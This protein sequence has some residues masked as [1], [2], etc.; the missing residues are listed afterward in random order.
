LYTA[1]SQSVAVAVNLQTGATV[2]TLTSPHHASQADLL[3][4]TTGSQHTNN[5][6]SISNLLWMGRVD[7]TISI[8]EPLTG[9]MD[10]QFTTAELMSVNDMLLT[11]RGV[12][13]KGRTSTAPG[14]GM[15]SSNGDDDD[16]QRLLAS[17]SDVLVS[18]TSTATTRRHNMIATPSGSLAFLDEAG[19]IAWVAHETFDTPVAFALDS[20]TGFSLTIEYV[21]DA[22]APNGSSDHI[23]KEMKRQLELGL[24]DA[25]STALTRAHQDST[26]FGSLPQSGQL[27]A[28]PLGQRQP[29]E[30]S[31]ASESSASHHPT[32]N[33]ASSSAL[34]A[35]EQNTAGSGR[36][37]HQ[38]SDDNQHY[39]WQHHGDSRPRP[40]SCSP[41]NPFYP[42]CL[43]GSHDR[44]RSHPHFIPEAAR[45]S[46]FEVGADG[47]IVPFYHPEYGYR[48][49][50]PDQFYM[51]QHEVYNSRKRYQKA[52]MVFGSWLPAL[53]VVIF[54][55]VR[56][57]VLV[58]VS[59]IMRFVLN[60][61]W[62]RSCIVHSR[63]SL[64]G[65]RSKKTKSMR[66]W[67]TPR[68]MQQLPKGKSIMA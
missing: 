9:A 11:S 50:P 68:P 35:R 38:Y 13:E 29:S 40:M 62:F 32:S 45:G 19:D 1:H 47:A 65:G 46:P 39:Q 15:A 57:T 48:Y 41:G 67:P 51:L 26:I 44:R 14:T 2:N 3:K 33:V 49:I 20:T 16:V 60:A 66:N 18:S 8:H 10:V 37:M 30:T 52:L 63:L 56:Q 34:T 25:T 27:F 59:C 22:V 21:P 4:E 42:K 55:S 54:V 53:I 12:G 36:I 24:V 7:H 31:V 58:N 23:V 64:A 17:Q 6:G 5:G 61:R 43:P 28:L